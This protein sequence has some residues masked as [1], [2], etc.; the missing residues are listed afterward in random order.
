M[1]I[2]GSVL[3]GRP[4]EGRLA[5]CGSLRFVG[6]ARNYWWASATQRQARATGE[7]FQLLYAHLRLGRIRLLRYEFV[8][9][10]AATAVAP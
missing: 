1:W 2:A 7:V 3:L 5:W 10:P 9:R 6:S 4:H 8:R